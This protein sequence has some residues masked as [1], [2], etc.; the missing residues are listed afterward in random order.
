MTMMIREFLGDKGLQVTF[1]V[2]E[3]SKGKF[4][5]KESL[6]VLN[7]NPISPDSIMVDIEGIHVGPTRNYTWY[8]EKALRESVLSWTKPYLRPLIMHHNENDG[9]II[10]R[11][12]NA[13]YTDINTLSGTGALLFTTN[14]PDKDGMEQVKD[15]RLK[16]TSIGAIVHDATCSVCGHNIAQEGPC[17]HE[18][19][20]VYEGQT[21]YW[22]INSMEAKELS[23]V[24]VPSDIYAQNIRIY[25]PEKKLINNVKENNKKGVLDMNEGINRAEKAIID[26]EVKTEKLDDTKATEAPKNQEEKEDYKKLYE[27]TKAK[28]DKVA[29]KLE[30]IVAELKQAQ[31]ELATKTGELKQEI[32][33]KEALE[34]DLFNNKKQLKE[35]V[36]DKIIIIKE[37]LGKKTNAISLQERSIESLNDTVLDLKEEL[38]SSKTILNNITKTTNP[39]LP[40]NFQEKKDENVKNSSNTSNIDLTE[41]FNNLFSSIVGSRSKNNF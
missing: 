23:Y 12:Q 32:E 40:T 11:I 31:N 24:I 35:A 8:T 29:S 10:G 33:T 25:N 36:I 21:C 30:A 1:N 15:G 17:E 16:T 14:I 37:N 9:K 5:L 22:V 34:N 28:H 38:G 20:Q 6:K 4:D 26:E 3:N 41:E 19:G 13:A 39:T 27:D 7:D 2:Q 18:R